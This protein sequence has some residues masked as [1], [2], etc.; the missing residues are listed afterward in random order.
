MRGLGLEN[1]EI[2]RLLSETADLM[3]IA[4]EDGFRIR[5]YRNAAAAVE[6]YPEKIEDIVC[7]PDRKATEN[8]GVGKGIAAALHDICE[9]GSF[10]VRDQL[11]QR[12]PASGLVLL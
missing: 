9:R 11:L 3:E 8:P 5:S 6:T 4:G 10:P 12:F 2:A 7:N 1:K